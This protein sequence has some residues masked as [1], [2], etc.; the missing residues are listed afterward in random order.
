M[1][2][3]IK[4]LRQAKRT[5]MNALACNSEIYNKGLITFIESQEIINHQMQQFQK[6]VAEIVFHHFPEN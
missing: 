5:F 1:E 4:A 3:S 6:T 2:E